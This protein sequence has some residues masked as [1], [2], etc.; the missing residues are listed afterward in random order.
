MKSLG[1]SATSDSS[2]TG[3][4][5]GAWRR[6]AIVVNFSTAQKGSPKNLAEKSA[7]FSPAVQPARGVLGVQLGKPTASQVSPYLLVSACRQL[8]AYR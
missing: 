1:Q 5:E 6:N 2:G 7:V 4:K 8:C 3:V